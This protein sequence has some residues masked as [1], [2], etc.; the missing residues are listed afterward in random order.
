[1]LSYLKRFG[2]DVTQFHVGLDHLLVQ[3]VLRELLQ[4]GLEG[5]GMRDEFLDLRTH[6]G[7]QLNLNLVLI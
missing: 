4:Q 7:H 6:V 3:D 1:M 2:E 5:F